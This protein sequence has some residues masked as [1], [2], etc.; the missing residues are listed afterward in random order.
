MARR[1][2]GMP[3]GDGNSIPRSRCSERPSSHHPHTIPE[4]AQRAHTRF[5]R[6]RLRSLQG[7]LNRGDRA[8]FLNGRGGRAAPVLEIIALQDSNR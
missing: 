4:E 7:N 8:L 1:S 3:P 6:D 5:V 2:G